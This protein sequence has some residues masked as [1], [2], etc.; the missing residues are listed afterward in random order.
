MSELF[1]HQRGSKLSRKNT[2]GAHE[3]SD[4]RTDRSAP[5]ESTREGQRWPDAIAEGRGE[6]GV[7]G[8]A[9]AS[10]ERKRAGR[11]VEA[12]RKLCELEQM[13]AQETWPGRGF[14]GRAENQQDAA[15]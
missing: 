9:P 14:Q 2:Q 8:E 12:S 10:W 13:R 15:G 1:G 3:L 4:G 7:Q 11:C 6:L 5:W